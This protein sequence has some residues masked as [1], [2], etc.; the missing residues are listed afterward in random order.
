MKKNDSSFR[1]NSGVE[2]KDI[3]SDVIEEK[4]KEHEESDSSKSMEY[5]KSSSSSDL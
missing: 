5:E 2:L 1:A 4:E 3:V